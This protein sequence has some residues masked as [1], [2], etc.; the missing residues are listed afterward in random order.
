MRT[1]ALAAAAA[2]AAVL[3]GGCGEL[4]TAPAA[5]PPGTAAALSPAA[6]PDQLPLPA[7]RVT[8]LSAVLGDARERVLPSLHDGAATDQALADL[9]GALNGGSVAQVQAS[10]RQALAVLDATAQEQPEAAAEL[11]AIRLAVSE[12]LAAAATQPTEAK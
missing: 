10:A 2:A 6:A 5:A 4:P 1:S 11:D 12:V 7:A 8:A 3:A 9:G